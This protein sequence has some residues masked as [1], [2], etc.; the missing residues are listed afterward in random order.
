MF[1]HI[2][3]KSALLSVLLTSTILVGCSDGGDTSPP[4]AGAPPPSSGPSLATP[5]TPPFA[6]VSDS[7]KYAPI[8]RY[9]DTNLGSIK[10]LIDSGKEHVQDGKG[11]YRSASAFLAKVPVPRPAQYKVPKVFNSAHGNVMKAIGVEDA[12]VRGLTGENVVVG[13]V[14]TGFS[15]KGKY[16]EG[17]VIAHRNYVEDSVENGPNNDNFHGDQ[18]S[19]VI[20]GNL[21]L[22]WQSIGFT[23]GIAPDAKLSQAHFF[24]RHKSDVY[25]EDF[26][27]IYA[28][29]LKD[30][31]SIVNH[32]ISTSSTDL[33][34]GNAP[35][36]SVES[37]SKIASKYV[38]QHGMLL[39]FSAGNDSYEYPSDLAA[40]QLTDKR[41]QTGG[42]LSVVALDMSG[43]LRSY[44]NK[45]G[46]V[47]SWCLGAPVNINMPKN[48]YDPSPVVFGGTSTAAPVISATAALVKE[49][50]PYLKGDQLGQV[51]L[52]TAKDIGAPGVDPV[53]GYGMVDVAKAIRGPGKFD[54]GDFNV[55][56]KGGSVWQNDISGAGGLVK[57][58][59]GTLR[60]TGYSSYTGGTKILVGAVVVNGRVGDVDVHKNGILAGDGMVGNVTSSGIVHAGWPYT[61]KLSIDGDYTNNAGA[62]SVVLGSKLDVS[63]KA[64]LNGGLLA[65]DGV[66]NAYVRT[67]ASSV[68]HAKGGIEGGFNEFDFRSSHLVDGKYL[69]NSKDVI[70]SYK[71]NKLTD[72]NVCGSGS[73]CLSAN[74]IET[75]VA[76]TAAKTGE[77]NIITATNDLIKLGAGI[78]SLQ[79]ADAVESALQEVSGHLHPSMIQVGMRSIDLPMTNVG[80][81]V[82]RLK[83]DHDFSAGY[84][85]SAF[86]GEGALQSS[87]G[88]PAINYKA[89]GAL[90]GVDTR[91]NP[92]LV[93]GLYGGWNTMS[94][95]RSQQENTS[96]IET[97]F[98]GA[99]LGYH[100]NRL[101]ISGQIAYGSQKYD[102]ARSIFVGSD[103]LTA[104][105]GGNVLAGRVEIG[106]DIAQYG[107]IVLTPYV[108]GTFIH[109]T[110]DKFA[111]TGLGAVNSNKS[112]NDIFRPEG[113]IRLGGK[114]G[115]GN[116]GGTLGFYGKAAIAKDQS[117]SQRK[118]SI[119]GH[120]FIAHG[121]DSGRT[122]AIFG[123]SS[124][125][126]FN[127]T[128][129]LT[130]GGE[131]QLPISGG[132]AS[133]TFNAALKLKF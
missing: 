51:I 81:R 8:L 95:T 1:S 74:L 77:T 60:L 75:S 99:Y 32:S 52:G 79:T 127:D 70:V 65:I 115:M 19:M 113:G 129:S 108:S 110:T 114:I 111:E 62:L 14:D 31:G 125:Y 90:L 122:K 72:A 76:T 43:N 112:F 35:S 78:Q 49:A 88:I 105:Y 7:N 67:G 29:I 30:G 126:N 133:N 116:N 26:D 117:S 73:A 101:N 5:E 56:F 100:P 18:S 25:F 48:A 85:A 20:S 94:V 47:A 63:G 83:L 87:N 34:E 128:L 28:N 96:N 107:S 22:K 71:V 132:K 69:V 54:W 89:G 17:K 68:L 106:Y 130:A 46:P 9:A 124:E 84:W 11:I 53:F 27:K 123:L 109:S 40:L 66:E 119:D 4:S 57:S 82:N 86:G 61:G 97:F 98:G 3:K 91:L 37:M 104:N 120:E 23:G 13:V 45:C 10:K 59:S 55:A 6:N 41:L 93:A 24:D 42:L 36:S 15:K 92:H 102:T 39:V 118:L 58:G 121:A 16:L 12:F 80:D 64:T 2:L 103:L 33:G 21:D 131:I 44:S 38:D 50:F